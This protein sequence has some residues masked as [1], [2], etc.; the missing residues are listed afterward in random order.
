MVHANKHEGMMS[1]TTQNR[2]LGM[3][4]VDAD[5]HR[6][7][8]GSLAAKTTDTLADIEERLESLHFLTN[9]RVVG[10]LITTEEKD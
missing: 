7:V 4:K 5:G 6:A 2:P 10:I 9:A 8:G 3:V 1:M